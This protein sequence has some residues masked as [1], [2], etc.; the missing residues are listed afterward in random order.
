MGSTVTTVSSTALHLI[1]VP[2]KPMAVTALVAVLTDYDMASLVL[3]NDMDTFKHKISSAFNYAENTYTLALPSGKTTQINTPTR[4]EIEDALALNISY[5]LGVVVTDF[6]YKEYQAYFDVL[7]W[8]IA[9]RNVDPLTDTIRS[10]PGLSFS[11]GQ[12]MQ[13]TGSSLSFD[14]ASVILNYDYYGYVEVQMDQGGDSQ[15]YTVVQFMKLSSHTDTVTRATT[16]PMMYK[17]NCLVAA[18]TKLDSL[19]ATL[20]G[21]YYWIYRT[22]LNTYPELDNLAITTTTDKYF[23]VIPIRYNNVDLTDDTLDQTPLYQTSKRL[24]QILDLPFKRLGEKIEASPDRDS[25]DHAYVMFGADL[26]SNEPA[27]LAYLNNYFDYLSTLNTTV[28]GAADPSGMSSYDRLPNSTFIEHG[29]S[30]SIQFDSITTSYIPGHIEDGKVGNARKTI[31]SSVIDASVIEGALSQSYTETYL[32]LDMQ[33]SATTM[34]RVTIKNLQV[35]N[36]VDGW[37]RVITTPDMI[38][39]DPNNHNCII[40]LE[41]NLTITLP[42][43]QLNNLYTDC[44]LLVINAI[45]KQHLQWYEE[46]WFGAVIMFVAFAI[47]VW[48]FNYWIAGLALAFT[49]GVVIAGV[50]FFGIQAVLIYLTVTV[51]V[52]LAIQTAMNWVVKKYGAKMGVIGAIVLTIVAMIA[53]Q[54]KAGFQILANYTLQYSQLALMCASALIQSTNDLIAAATQAVIDEYE[55]FTDLL[56][57]AEEALATNEAVKQ[58][59]FE[60]DFDLFAINKSKEYYSIPNEYPDAFFERTLGLPYN[61]TYGI[62]EAVPNFC[63]NLLTLNTSTVTL[64]F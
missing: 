8:L 28:Y 39:D 27:T 42:N 31:E 64:A 23:P 30:L 50:A 44:L 20:P 52:S 48:S 59:S 43:S 37:Y 49:E 18:Y 10:Y 61:N 15:P 53:S 34:R 26:Q 38:R 11:N 13:I 32:I 47:A 19:G 63:K 29:L 2:K 17:D 40:P 7:D 62:H 14:D 36:W 35:T 57:K 55:A 58:L 1:E 24:L 41:Y 54:G 9:N 4:T 5:P 56:K 60:S 6:K 51:L 21:S 12:K 33:V 25:I 16:L 46:S 22:Y 3:Q 45:E